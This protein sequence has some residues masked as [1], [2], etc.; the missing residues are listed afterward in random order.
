MEK[1]DLIK[2]SDV[3][4]ALWDYWY[5]LVFEGTETEAKDSASFEAFIILQEHM[6]LAIDAIDADGI[7]Y[8]S[9]D[10][11]GKLL[12]KSNPAHK[13]MADTS[14]MLIAY[15]NRYGLSEWDRKNNRKKFDMEKDDGDSDDFGDI[16]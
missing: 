12:K 4:S 16:R 5:P 11:A 9:T 6:K 14:R 10:A 3:R 1:T 2:K 7:L 15:Y 13:I 8:E